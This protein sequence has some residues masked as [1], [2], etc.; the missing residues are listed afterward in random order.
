[1]LVVQELSDHYISERRMVAESVVRILPD[2]VI[3]LM[4]DEA[5]FHLSGSVNKGNCLYW[6]K[7]NTQQLH[8][9][10]LHSALETV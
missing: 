4:T 3:T 10:P 2:N 1:M 5:H 8:E 7:E 9:P 6:A